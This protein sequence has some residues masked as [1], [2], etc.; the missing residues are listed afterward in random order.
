MSSP[1]PGMSIVS[2]NSPSW[3]E[4]TMWPATVSRTAGET[5]RSAA[6][7]RHAM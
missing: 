7:P 6:T 3:N 5:S 4:K 2:I 1:S